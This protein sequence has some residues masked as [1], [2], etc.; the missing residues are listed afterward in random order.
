MRKYNT[1]ARRERAKDQKWNCRLN[2]RHDR[3]VCSS[4][5]N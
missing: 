4:S 2:R 5:K 1:T 3:R